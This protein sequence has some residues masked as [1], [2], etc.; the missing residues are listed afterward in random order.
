MALVLLGEVALGK[1]D[2]RK[3]IDFNLPNTM[4]KKANSVHALGRLEPSE[5]EYIDE[6]V[7]V[8][9]GDAKINEKNSL[10]NDHAEYIVYNTDPS[11][12]RYLLQIKYN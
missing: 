8:P 7:F 5:G 4:D 3:S 2:Q 11:R 12:L 9:N 10:C 6:D 1:E